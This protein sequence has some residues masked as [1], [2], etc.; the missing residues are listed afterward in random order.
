MES[1]VNTPLP[2]PPP[3]VIQAFITPTDPLLTLVCECVTEDFLEPLLIHRAEA[4]QKPHSAPSRVCATAFGLKDSGTV[5]G[6]HR[7]SQQEPDL[8]GGVFQALPHLSIPE[9]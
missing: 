6:D 4:S 3:W 8:V 7:I 1:P 2:S 5:L 9:S